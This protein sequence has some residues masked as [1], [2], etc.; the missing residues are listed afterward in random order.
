[1]SQSLDESSDTLFTVSS[2]RVMRLWDLSSMKGGQAGAGGKPFR[3]VK[4]RR[5][6]FLSSKNA[7]AAKDGK[8]RR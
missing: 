4:N 7:L 3:A 1:M 8:F 5:G 2:D 6:S